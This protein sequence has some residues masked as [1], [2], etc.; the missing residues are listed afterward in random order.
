MDRLDHV[1]T[2]NLKNDKDWSN[3]EMNSDPTFDTRSFNLSRGTSNP[4]PVITVSLQVGNKHRATTVAGLTCWWG[5][6]DTNR[7]IKRIHTNHYECNM[8]SNKVEYSTA[9]GVYFTTH[10]VK[11]PFCMP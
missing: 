2:D 10:D 1:V 11:V 5:S 8:Q 4:L 6:G 3:E 7:M 9:T